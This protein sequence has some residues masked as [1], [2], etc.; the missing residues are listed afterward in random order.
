MWV[1]LVVAVSILI[2]WIARKR[3]NKPEPNGPGQLKIKVE[4]IE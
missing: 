4:H 1:T 2:F 3:V